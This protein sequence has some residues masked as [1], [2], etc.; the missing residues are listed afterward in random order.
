ARHVLLDVARLSLD[1]TADLGEP[2]GE[3]LLTPTRIYTKSCLA[4]A[5]TLDVHAFAH[6]TGGGLGANLARVLPPGLVAHLDRSSWT[7]P[8][9]FDLIAERGAVVAD[10]MERTFNLGVGMVAIVP[11][12]AAEATV[13]LL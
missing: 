5:K 3:V 4:L 11:D 12:A 13:T 1:S 2:L 8:A 7:V 6:V 9:V 10:E